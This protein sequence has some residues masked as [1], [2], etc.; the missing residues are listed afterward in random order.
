MI[1][2]RKLR[3]REGIPL[4]RSVLCGAGGR[5]EANIEHSFGA[6]LAAFFGSTLGHRILGPSPIPQSS[7]LRK[8]K[9]KEKSTDLGQLLL[10]CYRERLAI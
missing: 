6:H 9:V 8:W 1:K 7:W 4:E 3:K 5:G 2:Y 10:L